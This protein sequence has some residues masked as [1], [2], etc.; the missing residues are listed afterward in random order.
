MLENVKIAPTAIAPASP[1]T[2]DLVPILSVPIL[3]S[4]EL[5]PA[6]NNY[7]LGCG[8]VFTRDCTPRPLSVAQWKEIIWA[9][10]SHIINDFAP[11]TMGWVRHLIYAQ[12]EA[13]TGAFKAKLA[14]KLPF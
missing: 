13:S 2:A 11:S 10:G 9:L 8:N 3:Y 4:L 7:C 12:R 1:M 5:T 6:C 14:A